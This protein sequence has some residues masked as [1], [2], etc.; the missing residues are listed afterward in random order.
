MNLVTGLK[1]IIVVANPRGQ[2]DTA[3]EYAW[4]RAVN[5]DARITLAHELPKHARTATETSEFPNSR[6]PN[7][8]A[9]T[10]SEF[11]IRL[12]EQPPASH[13]M[14]LARPACSRMP[15]LCT[16][17]EATAAHMKRETCA[18]AQAV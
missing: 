13:G 2:S 17:P 8:R 18:P 5:S 16:P 10:L 15:V 6:F 1:T 3:L 9:T 12:S 11:W 4:R 7:S 14:R